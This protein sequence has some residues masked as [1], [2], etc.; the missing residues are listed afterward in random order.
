LLYPEPRT[1]KLEL[2]NV[3]IALENPAITTFFPLLAEIAPFSL[4]LQLLPKLAQV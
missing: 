3:A 1:E 4:T 2:V